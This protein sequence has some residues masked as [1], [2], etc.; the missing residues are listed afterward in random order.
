MV[1]TLEHPSAGAV[2]TLGIPFRFSDTPASIRRPPPRLSEHT[3]EVL[4]ALGYTEAQIAAL[5][6]QHIV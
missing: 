2:R 4:A 3:D 1:R 5:K 6:G